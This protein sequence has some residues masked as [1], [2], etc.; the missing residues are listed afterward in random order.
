MGIKLYNKSGIPDAVLKPLLMEAKR[1]ARCGGS[2]VVKA[3]RGGS[4]CASEACS[5][6]HVSRYSLTGKRTRLG[7]GLWKRQWV[8][9]D[10]G[11]VYLRPRYCT[12]PVAMA[13][14]LF[15]TAIHEFHHIRE[16]QENKHDVPWSRVKN[17]RR[18]NW[19]DRPEEVRAMMGA[20]DAMARIRKSPA[21][22][23]R[24]EEAILKVALALE[25]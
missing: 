15:V 22:L 1:A 25:A 6:S 21:R 3:T 18:P 7:N 23:A 16:F 11:A 12:D 20:T 8:A 2:V 4:R 10:G 19:E 17:G 24:V 5:Y 14:R 13:E 9:T